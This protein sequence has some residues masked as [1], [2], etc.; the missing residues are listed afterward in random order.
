MGKL[1]AGGGG[2]KN[3]FSI[4]LGLDRHCFPAGFVI[5]CNHI[6]YSTPRREVPYDMINLSQR[7]V[8]LGTAK[9]E[10]RE[11]FAFAQARAGGGGRSRWMIFPSEIPVCP[12]R[13]PSRNWFISSWTRWTR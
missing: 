3:H 10:I 2:R 1:S 9:S 13:I 7:M 12:P 11:A 4:P 5:Y 6:D 8:A